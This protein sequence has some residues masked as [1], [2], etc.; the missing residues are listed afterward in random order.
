MNEY[1]NHPKQRNEERWAEIPGYDG[2]YEISDQGRVK[3]RGRMRRAVAPRNGRE[4]EYMTVGRILKN[5]KSSSGYW[6]VCL[7]KNGV[8]SIKS[9][10]RMMAVAFIPNNNNHPF[11]NH[12]DG[13]KSNNSL[14][15]LEWCTNSQNI[16]HAY[17]VLGAVA[18]ARGRTGALNP[19]S[20][21]VVQRTMGGDIVKTW[22]AAAD[23]H[24]AGFDS[25]CITRCCQGKSTYHKGF[26]WTYA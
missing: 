12:K 20:K 6:Q 19:H 3:S 2:L 26:L 1:R 17:E 15:N 24:R 5:Q 13:D 8:G 25:G 7:H 14:D 22:E 4:Y 11:I 16:K 21:R 9:I 23:A 18:W 10:H